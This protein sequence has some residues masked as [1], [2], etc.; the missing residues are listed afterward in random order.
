MPQESTEK[1]HIKLTSFKNLAAQIKLTS[2]QVFLTS[3]FTALYGTHAI[4]L[5]YLNMW[6]KHM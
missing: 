3:E 6:E 1:K 4:K 5:D 2:Q